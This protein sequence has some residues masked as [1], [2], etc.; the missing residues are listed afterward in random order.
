MRLQTFHFKFLQGHLS[1]G[2]LQEWVGADSRGAKTNLDIQVLVNLDSPAENKEPLRQVRELPHISDAIQETQFFRRL[3]SL[4]LLSASLPGRHHF[5][6][7]PRDQ[8][9]LTG[10]ILV[11]RDD[12]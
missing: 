1:I 5:G 11:S 10:A 2:D 3:D 4:H 6:G 12:K 7:S 8:D 9:T